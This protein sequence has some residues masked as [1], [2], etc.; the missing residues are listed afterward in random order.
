MVN[1]IIN[2]AVTTRASDIHIEP[3]ENQVM[4]RYRIDGVLH[5]THQLP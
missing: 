3:Q 2:K 1:M 4:V 5:E